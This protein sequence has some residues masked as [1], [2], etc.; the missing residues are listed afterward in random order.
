M[1]CFCLAVSLSLVPALALT[2]LCLCVAGETELVNAFQVITTEKSFTVMADTPQEKDVWLL[3][4]RDA[5][6]ETKRPRSSMD[7][8]QPR[9]AA[10]PDAEQD[11]PEAPVWVPDRM[12]TQCMICGTTFSVIKRRV[13]CCRHLPPSRCSQ[14]STITTV[15]VIC[16]Q[17]HCRNCGKVVCGACSSQ[18]VVIPG[19]D[20]QRAER[21]CSQCYDTISKELQ[22]QG[23]AR[24]GPAVV[25]PAPASPVVASPDS[26]RG[27]RRGAL[28]RVISTSFDDAP[29]SSP[30][31]P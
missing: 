25:V 12:A 15:V 5:L 7:G 18:K 19:L 2:P 16:S 17:H 1:V 3:A 27:P 4:F 31:Q 6:R 13:C 22:A 9:T 29:A 11:S 21:V 26:A 24:A 10:A 20:L 14:A 28:R 23:D 8:A 30:T